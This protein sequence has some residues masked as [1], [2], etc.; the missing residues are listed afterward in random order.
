MGRFLVMQKELADMKD[1]LVMET[2]RFC[3]NVYAGKHL[4]VLN[5]IG[6]IAPLIGLLGAYYWNDCC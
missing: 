4:S 2:G 3:P 1:E 5:T 6:N